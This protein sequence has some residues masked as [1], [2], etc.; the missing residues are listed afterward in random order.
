MKRIAT[1]V[2]L[3]GLTAQPALALRVDTGVDASVKA[4]VGTDAGVYTTLESNATATTN[5]SAASDSETA[6]EVSTDAIV[7]TAGDVDETEMNIS[8]SA[9]VN[10]KADLSS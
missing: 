2:V 7:V 6:I 1:F 3:L 4:D 8:S 10:S 9:E 5:A